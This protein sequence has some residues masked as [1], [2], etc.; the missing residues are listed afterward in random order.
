MSNEKHTLCDELL[1]FIVRH[2]VVVLAVDLLWS[3]GA[4]AVGHAGP[5]SARLHCHQTFDDAVLVGAN[6]NDRPAMV[7]YN[8]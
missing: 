7:E 5:V 8:E 3:F 1:H 6:N 4:S 2:K